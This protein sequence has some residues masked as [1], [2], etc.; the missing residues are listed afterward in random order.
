MKTPESLRIFNE[1]VNEITV[2]QL[3]IVMREKSTEHDL[4]FMIDHL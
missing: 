1:C 3:S 4:H 2:E